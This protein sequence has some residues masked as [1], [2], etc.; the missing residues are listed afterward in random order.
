MRIDG[1][2]MRDIRSYYLWIEE[3]MIISRPWRWKSDGGER[4][5]YTPPVP[6]FLSSL[7][8]QTF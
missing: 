2:D 4:E 3:D 7:K 1:L 8:S 6:L 5:T